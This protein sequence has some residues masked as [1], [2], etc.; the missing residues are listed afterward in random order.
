[1]LED[2][3]GARGNRALLRGPELKDIAVVSV[4]VVDKVVESSC[5]VFFFVVVVVVVVLVVFLVERISFRDV[6]NEGSELV[7]DGKIGRVDGV[8]LGGGLGG[9]VIPES[10]GREGGRND[11]VEE[12]EMGGTVEGVVVFVLVADAGRGD[13]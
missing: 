3:L 9:V 5:G 13:G 4:A 8:S 11:V 7:G 2:A 6:V 10:R 1:M 12:G